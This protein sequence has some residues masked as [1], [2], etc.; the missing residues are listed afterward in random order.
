MSASEARDI[1]QAAPDDG[2]IGQDLPQPDTHA[3]SD[4][5]GKGKGKAAEVVVRVRCH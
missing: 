4:V 3:A 1:Q 2:G 5:K